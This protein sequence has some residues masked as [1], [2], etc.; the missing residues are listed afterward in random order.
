LFFLLSE[1]EK[2]NNSIVILVFQ[3]NDG[4]IGHWVNFGELERA[5]SVKERARGSSFRD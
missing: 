2:I 5:R 4:V 1:T 3:E